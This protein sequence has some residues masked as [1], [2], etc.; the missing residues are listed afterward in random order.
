MRLVQFR[1][2]NFRSISDSGEI[3]VARI[4]ALLGRNESGKTNILRALSSLNPAAPRKALDPVKNFP[5]HR[6]LKECT[7]ETPVVDSTWELTDAESGQLSSLWPRSAR[8][9]TVTVSRGYGE[10]LCVGI[11]ANPIAF[12]TAGIGKNI[13]KIASAVIALVDD[14]DEEKKP[15]LTS[16][17]EAFSATVPTDASGPKGWASAFAPAS[18]TLRKAIAKA[19]V[20]LTDAQ[21][22]S[23]TELETAADS[24]AQDDEKHAKARGWVAKNLPT[25]VYIDE[26]PDLEGHKNIAE[27][28][29]RKSQ[30]ALTDSDIN[31]EKMCQVA[32][33][34]PEKLNELMQSGHEERNQLANRAGAVITGELRELW[35]D[36]PLKVRFH[37]DGQHFD[38]FISDPNRTYDVEVTLGERSRGFQ[39]FFAFY[40]VFAA[41]TKG[42]DKEHA[43]LLLDE[44]G[45]YLHARSQ[46]DL[47]QHFDDDFEN[48]IIYSTHSPFMVPTKNLERVRTVNIDEAA[49][50]TVTNDPTGDARTLFPLQAALGYDLAQSLF[51]SGRNLV[52]EGV[53]DY[54]FISSVSECLEDLDGGGLKG[55]TIT[56]AGGAQ[57]VPYMASLLASEALDVLVLLDLEKDAA[58]TKD[59]L[60]KGKL[61]VDRNILSIGDAYDD[62]DRPEEA[63][64]EDLVDPGIY[65]AL[66]RES[67]AKELEGK[68]LAPNDRIPRI[69]KRMEAAFR[70]VG[71]VFHKTRPARLFLKKMG[72]DPSSVLADSSVTRF[73]RLFSAINAA[74]KEHAG[75]AG[76]PFG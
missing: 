6:K 31:F 39:W 9:K 8:V 65:L 71:L 54:W 68:K 30:G 62:A 47:L 72:E 43:I 26:Y 25:I 13:R 33:I 60:V 7:L 1:I 3:E 20:E 74:A 28:L 49:G 51:V 61:V 66:V 57:K 24:I 35:K 23:L 63:D 58:T 64:I 53:T 48:Q 36:R 56:P 18:G 15:S 32:D 11:P 4:T 17:A 2:R 44:P 69:A 5:R 42:G 21:E 29:S 34:E 40:M 16:A 46:G 22:A 70:D 67:Y 12:D 55:L 75:R 76:K 41:D 50:T 27:Y 73:R 52:V 37:T 45:L 19:D 14:V 10:K 59:G 38:T